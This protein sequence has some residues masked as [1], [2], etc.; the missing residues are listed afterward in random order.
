MFNMHEIEVP[1]QRGVRLGQRRDEEEVAGL[2][3]NG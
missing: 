3:Q 1:E 2:F